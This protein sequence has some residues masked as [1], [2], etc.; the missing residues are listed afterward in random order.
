MFVTPYLGIKKKKVE[1][2]A[3]LKGITP[4]YVH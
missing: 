4:A 3:T 1:L 2:F